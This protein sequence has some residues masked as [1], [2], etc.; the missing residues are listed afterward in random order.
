MRQYILA[1]NQD[2]TRF[3]LESLIRQDEDNVLHRAVDKA[4]LVQ[5][6]K[7]HENAVVLLDY[8]LFDFA[9]VEQLLIVGERFALSQWILISDELTPAF[10]RR[11]VYSSH[12]F[13]IVFKDGPLRDVREALQAVVQHNRFISQRALEV[14]IN[15]QQEEDERPSVLTST[16]IEIVKAIAQGK[17]TKEIA[18]ERFSSIHTI[19]THRKNIFRKLGVNTAHEVIKY[20]LR[21]GLVDS[22][23]FYI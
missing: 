12:Q 14:I 7:E 17:S 21:A 23:E 8:T 4:G 20:A 13:S 16:E 5:L 1:D 10:I 22:S 6:L 2:L 15:H 19:T 18:N 3:A 9:D 11:V